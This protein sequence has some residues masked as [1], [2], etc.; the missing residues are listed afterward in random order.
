[1]NT[2]KV[3]K[4]KAS[5]LTPSWKKVHLSAVKKPSREKPRKLQT[6]FI[7]KTTL[8]L[9][10][11]GC[12]NDFNLVLAKEEFIKLCFRGKPNI[13]GKNYVERVAVSGF[14][15]EVGPISLKSHCCLNICT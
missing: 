8:V 4:I 12:L 7:L 5:I 9:S 1:M 15:E 6:F 2:R 3:N 10:Y 11:V 14:L 13:Y